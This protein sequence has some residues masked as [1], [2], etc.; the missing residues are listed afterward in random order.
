[1]QCQYETDGPRNTYKR[2][3]RRGTTYLVEAPEGTAHPRRDRWIY[4]TQHSMIAQRDR[5]IVEA[6]PRPA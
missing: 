2:C 3:T 1:M 6:F 4:C 5:I